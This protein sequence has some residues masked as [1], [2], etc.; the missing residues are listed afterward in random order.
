[1]KTIITTLLLAIT[2]MSTA[3]SDVAISISQDA[4]LAIT[5]DDNGNNAFT[6]NVILRLDLQDNQRRLG[7]YIIGLEYEYAD[8]NESLYQRYSLN[9]GYTFNKFSILGNN[10][11]E[12]TALLN[13]GMTIREVTQVDKKVNKAFT[14]FAFSF[15]LAYPI[16]SRF[17]VQLTGQLSHRVDKNTL[18]GSDANYTFDALQIDFSGFIGFQYQIPMTKKN[19]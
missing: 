13:Y 19:F 3:Q 15:S 18:Y 6:P 14:G 17:K 12:A 5:G 10:K 11:L 8:L 2:L 7:Y 16:T 9:L 4:R 1:M